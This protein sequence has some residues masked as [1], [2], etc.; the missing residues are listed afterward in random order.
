MNDVLPKP[1][2]KE[3]ML[4]TLEKHLSQ[5]KK[6]YAPQQGQI[7]DQF[8]TPNTPLGLNMGHMSAAQSLKEEQS[9][10]K[11]GSPT[12]S[13]HSPNQIGA[14]P[15]TQQSNHNYVQ[16]MHASQGGPFMMAPTHGNVG[17]GYQ[18]Q[19]SAPVMAVPTGRPGQ[20]RRGISDIGVASDGPVEKRQRMYPPSQGGFTR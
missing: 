12:S 19:N 1:F 15:N 7:Q 18:T 4:R 14:S 9:P 13:W 11:S 5:F 2:T 17:G 20:H 16:Q 6:N 3:G 10:G 8:A